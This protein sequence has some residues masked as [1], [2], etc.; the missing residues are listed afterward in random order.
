MDLILLIKEFHM[1][2]KM[3]LINIQITSLIQ[4]E[5]IPFLSLMCGKMPV[6]LFSHW[7]REWHLV[8]TLITLY[9]PQPLQ[10]LIHLHLQPP[11]CLC[12]LLR[13][14][15][16]EPVHLLSTYSPFPLLQ[17][18]EYHLS[19]PQVYH[20]YPSK[21]PL[22]LSSPSVSICSSPQQIHLPISPH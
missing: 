18:S 17:Q 19:F 6:I 4:S 14:P 9:R 1:L 13:T 15:T 16:R 22:I 5:T 20:I 12:Q 2:H 8:R 11:I 21:I 10:L 7:K 3:A